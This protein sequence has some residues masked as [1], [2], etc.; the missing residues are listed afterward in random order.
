MRSF[1]IYLE[2]FNVILEL[3]K[4]LLQI[5]LKDRFINK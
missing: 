5:F 2:S 4:N 1:G 3:K